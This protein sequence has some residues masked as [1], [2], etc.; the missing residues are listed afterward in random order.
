MSPMF[1]KSP[2]CVGCPACGAAYGW[3]C[4]DASGVPVA[5]HEPRMR[6]YAMAYPKQ[7]QGG[8]EVLAHALEVAAGHLDTPATREMASALRGAAAALRSKI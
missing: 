1:G 2:I 3:A 8:Y 5:N 4:H 7:E 6:A